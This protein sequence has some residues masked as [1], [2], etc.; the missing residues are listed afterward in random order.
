LLVDVT[1]LDQL[2]GLDED[3]FL[4]YE[5]VALCRSAR[6][7]GR[8]VEYD[9]SVEVVH[10]RPLQAREVTP[11]LRVI[12][13]HSKL[14]YFRKYRP[15]IEFTS[16]AR[17]IGWEARARGLWSRV[18]GRREH[19][20]AW[21]TIGQMARALRTGG[22]IRGPEVLALA[23]RPHLAATGGRRLRADRPGAGN[24]RFRARIGF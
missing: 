5:E 16:L 6:S 9:P 21:S 18:R 17:I 15:H 19:S 11:K 20:I 4:Y 2:G 3:F 8:R 14:L 12:T 24:Q 13:R 22:E 7:L 23:Q 1:L 10:L